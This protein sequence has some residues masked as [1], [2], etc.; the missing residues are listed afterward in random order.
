MHYAA[1]RILTAVFLLSLAG[2]TTTPSPCPE[3]MP[4]LSD[5]DGQADSETGFDPRAEAYLKKYSLTG[6]DCWDG[7]DNA[8]AQYLLGYAY[9]NG[10]GVPVDTMRAL[11]YYVKASRPDR[12]PKY[13]YV[14]SAPV[15]KESYGRVIPVLS[16]Y[17]DRAKKEF[18]A[19]SRRLGEALLKN[20]DTSQKEQ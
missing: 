8:T 11:Q 6:L 18:I 19:A 10:F 7:V 3:K 5:F 17:N 4:H 12:T 9:E 20:T 1:R 15:G 16:G 13:T 14:Y 2:C